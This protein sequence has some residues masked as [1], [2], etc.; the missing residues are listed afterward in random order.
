MTIFASRLR[1]FSSGNLFSSMLKTYFRSGWAFFIPYLA[2]YLLYA[3]LR[4]PV[5]PVA[6]GAGSMEQ[7]AGGWV[8]CLLHVYWVLHAVHIVLGAFA[9]RA[10]WRAECK[11]QGA[12][13]EEPLGEFATSSASPEFG[14]FPVA[15]RLL[16]TG[17]HLLPWLCLAL[18][19]WIPGVYLE[20]PSD[21][22]QH[23]SRINE[24]N[25]INHVQEHAS[26]QK[27]SYFLAYSLIG[28]MAPPTLQLRGF[29]VYYTVSCLLLCWQYHRLATAVGLNRSAAFVF[30]IIQALTFGNNIFGFYRYYGMSSTIFAQ[31]GAIAL[32]RIAVNLGNRNFTNRDS[33]VPRAGAF[34]SSYLLLA[35][36]AGVIMLVAI[37]AFTHPQGLGIAALGI[38][39][40]AVWR[41]IE[42]RRAAIPW[43]TI[44]ALVLNWGAIEYF[45]R[46]PFLDAAYR[47]Q[48]WLTTW[49][50]FSIYQPSTPS[51]KL[52][53]SMLGGLGCLGLLISLPLLVRNH[54]AG[55]LT[56]MPVLALCMPFVSIPLANVLAKASSFE[57]GYIIAYSRMLLAIPS[58]LALVYFA[59]RVW[60][61][62]TR[63]FRGPLRRIWSIRGYSVTVLMALALCIMPASHPLFNRLY[64][65]ISVPPKDLSM[66]HVIDSEVLKS[67]AGLRALQEDLGPD[68]PQTIRRLGLLT[69]LGI[70]YAL[71]ST[72]YTSIAG[73][74]K[75]ITWPTR[76]PPSMTVA[77]KLE[78]LRRVD[79][80]Q[81]FPAVF[82][83]TNSLFSSGS[84]SGYLSR[85][86]LSHEVALE[87]A[88]QTELHVARPDPVTSRRP[89]GIWIEWRRGNNGRNI[90]G[91]GAGEQVDAVP[92][93][94]GRLDDSVESVPVGLNDE[95]IIKPVMHN[96]D[97]NGLAME[98]TIKG[99]RG[100]SSRWSLSRN[101][102]P[103]GGETWLYREYTFKPPFRGTYSIELKGITCWPNAIHSATYT[104]VVSDAGN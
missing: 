81:I 21:P 46:H 22:W 24:W 12:K 31:V 10:W 98:V 69:T 5:N 76:T 57:H 58:G 84:F 4:W 34:S 86:W 27:S 96:L 90:F 71:N 99:P 50:S 51:S 52:A 82:A 101:P 100:Y 19:F 14:G 73:A 75:W 30:V 41:L 47:D 8:P 72:G 59:A 83:P 35:S 93:Y 80:Q 60:G 67:F 104:L 15:D 94:R 42:W 29:D 17:Y 61:N 78:R 43:L 85:H 45:P 65:V 48:G 32:T 63:V 33:Y 23:F 1:S 62:S 7:G 26:W 66:A 103:L 56:W 3:W 53:I 102:D 28:K 97:G 55:W 49:Y 77:A 20:F 79:S 11:G 13:S 25:W 64:N 37:I 38:A 68:S 2:A 92:S 91:G 88:G 74:R 54:L 39:A 70:G 9:L 87:H 6:A 40:V 36:T 89:P 18:V 16:S 95:I 44:A